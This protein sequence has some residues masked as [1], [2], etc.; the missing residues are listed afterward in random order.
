MLMIP[1]LLLPVF[2]LKIR[3]SLHHKNPTSL[4]YT[5]GHGDVDLHCKKFIK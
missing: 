2:M 4:P 1:L 3:T 5:D